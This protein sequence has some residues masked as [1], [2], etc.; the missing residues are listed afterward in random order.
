MKNFFFSSSSN[1]IERIK[2]YFLIIFYVHYLEWS[3]KW[4]AWVDS[5]SERVATRNAKI[6]MEKR[7]NLLKKEKEMQ[8]KIYALYKIVY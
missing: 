4:D 8:T 5:N 6:G 7:K 2:C 3:S 1:F